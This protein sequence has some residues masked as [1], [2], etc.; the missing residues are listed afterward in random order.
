DQYRALGLLDR[1]IVVLFSDHGDEFMEH[2]GLD[3]G[4]SLYQEQI[5]VV[6]MIRFPGYARRHDVSTPVRTI[7][8][9]PTVFDA[10]GRTNPAGVDGRSLIPV[11]RGEELELPLF[12]ETDY[13]LFVH[14]RAARRDNLKLI[15]DLQDG[16]KE[17]YDLDADPGEKID[18][19][20]SDPRTTYELEQELRGWMDQTR[21]NPQDY[22]GIR[23]K[24]ITLF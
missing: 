9:F 8:L 13:R 11:L 24:P 20:S 1:T 5:H 18:I 15:L 17:L 19:S 10:L 4:A 3:H 12:A 21:T 14:M 23:Q 16:K 22:L 2:G 6:A 7:D